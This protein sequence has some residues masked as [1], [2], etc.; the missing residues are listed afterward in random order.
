MED[1]FYK[2]KPVDDMTKEE[3]REAIKCT[4]SLYSDSLERHLKEL[5]VLRRFRKEG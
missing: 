2:G 4:A 5:E 3:L 1:L